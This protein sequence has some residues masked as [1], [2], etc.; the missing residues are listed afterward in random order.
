MKEMTM[1]GTLP[2]VYYFKV[3]IFVEVHGHV[4]QQLDHH[5]PALCLPGKIRSSDSDAH[6]SDTTSTADAMPCSR[7]WHRVLSTAAANADLFLWW[8]RPSASCG[9]GGSVDSVIPIAF[10]KDQQHCAVRLCTPIAKP[11]A[12]SAKAGTI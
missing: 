1:L 7:P 4:N 11:A 10:R 12:Q 8:R 2:G 3:N 6:A 9:G 5:S